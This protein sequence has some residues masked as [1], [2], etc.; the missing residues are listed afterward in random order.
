MRS[1]SRSKKF[2]ILVFIL[3]LLFSPFLVDSE[4]NIYPALEVGDASV[5]YYQ[6]TTC[7]ISFFS[8]LR[9]NY[10]NLQNVEF[11]ENNYAS[12]D[13]LGKVTGLDKY[14]DLY[15]VSI[16]SNSIYT[17]FFQGIF[18]C[19]IL[20]IFSNKLNL[21]KV[22]SGLVFV[23][24]IFFTSQHLTEERFYSRINQYY[25][26][27]LEIGNKYLLSIFFSYYI[28]LLLISLVIE[29]NEKNIL[30]KFPFM[31]LVVGTF[32]G[33]NLNFYSL[34]FSYIG[35]KYLSTRRVNNLFNLIYLLFSIFWIFT[36]KD[37]NSFFDTDKLR[38]FVNSSNNIQSLI[39]WIILY[40][41][42]FNCFIY[43]SKITEL[44]YKQICRNFLISGNLVIVFGM[45]GSMSKLVNFMNFI[46]FGQNKKGIN[47][48]E[49]IA[50]NTWRGFSASAE[51]VAEF[52]GFGILFCFILILNKKIQLDL[53]LVAFML[54]PLYGL[55][56]ANN[57]AVFLSM[58]LVGFYFLYHKFFRS[59]LNPL[60]KKIY[61]LVTMTTMISIIL[62]TI[63]NS[64]DY[65]YISKLLIYESALQSN[66][67]S[68]MEVYGKWLYTTNYFE[69]N[70]IY[71]LIILENFGNPST[72]LVFL[73]Q[74]F[75]QENFNI[76]FI[77]NIVTVLS[78]LALLV[79]RSGLWAIFIAKY[80][81]NLL[82]TFF[83]NGPSQLNNYLYKLKVNL[84]AYKEVPESL[85]SSLFLPH[86]S[87]LDILV[88][89]G[90][91][92]FV[93]FIFWNFYLF[94]LKSIENSTKALLFFLL[95]NLAKSDSI[96]YINSFTLLIFVYILILQN[97]E[98]IGY[99]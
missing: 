32:N 33:F 45:L 58:G 88:F 69:N 6:S 13:C 1:I 9:E 85:P 91:V 19:C 95:I 84:F 28:I 52:L 86:S 41:L 54:L 57:F 96:L 55:L 82:E 25:S 46:I 59:K 61:L 11:R 35:L 74:V 71:S 50:G 72:S 44:N 80:N 99:V 66:F 70:E 73:T 18:W 75:H 98:K 40:F 97:K 26:S 92:G 49:S 16:G 47:T 65:D 63:F 37:L 5:G 48:F 94:R 77:P 79:N 62:Y 38:G 14:S 23:L 22:R 64:F 21:G 56:R 60:N 29:N 51:S 12:F 81:P 83:G 17:L 87:F 3:L 8:V 7:N 36:T 27:N 4:D 2:I 24:T 30:N 93:I 15:I 34:V 78:F 90:V 31:F 43:L 39:Y 20:I 76:P 53:K 67:F 89:Y 68:D 42:I 10:R